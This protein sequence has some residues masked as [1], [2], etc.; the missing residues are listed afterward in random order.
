MEKVPTQ[1]CLVRWWRTKGI[2]H[3][4]RG[5]KYTEVTRSCLAASVYI[6]SAS[7]SGE[8][9]EDARSSSAD[10]VQVKSAS[11][12]G[13]NSLEEEEGGNCQGPHKKN[14]HSAH[15]GRVGWRALR[16]FGT[17][18]NGGAFWRDTGRACSLT[19]CLPYGLLS[20][21]RIIYRCLASRSSSPYLHACPPYFVSPLRDNSLCRA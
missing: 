15:R 20:L 21:K 13:A 4:Q 1:V 9:K 18:A 17:L 11:S 8:D 6:E 5:N 10:L 16:G 3:P 7:S 2:I 12:S 14:G 19:L